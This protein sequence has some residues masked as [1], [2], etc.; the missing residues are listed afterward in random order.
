M[1]R[2]PVAAGIVSESEAQWIALE[3]TLGSHE[4]GF[5]C[6]SQ[7]KQKLVQYA[8]DNLGMITAIYGDDLYIG[9]QTSELEDE[10]F[11]EDSSDYGSL[12]PDVTR[13]PLI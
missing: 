3:F 11:D 4:H 12:I 2:L 9:T 6:G 13:E 8:L 5:I 7:D 1:L 10:D